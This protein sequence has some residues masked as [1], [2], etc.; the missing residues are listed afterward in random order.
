MESI[1]IIKLGGGLIAPKDWASNTLDTKLVC[2][3]ASEIKLL[4]AENPRIK[5]I[6]VCGSGNFGH[7]AVKKFDQSTPLGFA[8]IQQIA[9]KIAF[10]VAEVFLKK[11]VALT[12]MPPHALSDSY[13]Q[14]VKSLDT[15]LTPLLFGDIVMRNKKSEV[16]SGERI[17]S[18]LVK[19][20]RLTNYKVK[21]IIQLSNVDGVLDKNGKLIK[22]IN[23]ANLRIHK[24]NFYKPRSDV[25]GGMLH[26]VKESVKIAKKFG[27]STF[28]INGSNKTRLRKVLGGGS[29]V[30]TLIT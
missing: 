1:V 29:P 17:I 20:L 27:V 7:H 12:V 22:T 6:L 2:Q 5:L 14:I 11:G 10:E 4:I 3:I 25:T 24:K 13:G 30:G 23:S 16:L 26:K 15:N 18:Q 19:S 9:T 8:K 21:K 28:I